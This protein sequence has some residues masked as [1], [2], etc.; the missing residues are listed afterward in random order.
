MSNRTVGYLGDDPTADGRPLIDVGNGRSV[1][2]TPHRHIHTGNSYIAQHSALK[3]D[4]ELIEV[5]AAMPNVKKEAHLVITVESALASTFELFLATTKTHAA[6]TAITP[7]NR[8]RGSSNAAE[9][10]VCHTPG[11]AQAGSGNILRYIG[12]ASGFPFF[13]SVGGNSSTRNEIIVPRNVATL[14][15]L[16]SRANGNALDITFDWYEITEEEE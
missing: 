2:D 13:S 11:G 15:R 8:D 1:I 10:V 16:T 3:A 14:V 5:R 12:A 4:T 6:G 7:I 9:L